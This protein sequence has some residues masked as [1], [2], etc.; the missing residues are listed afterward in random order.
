MPYGPFTHLP[1][2]AVARHNLLVVDGDER[3]L[4]VLE[5]SLR[6]AGYNVA[7][8]QEVERALE[9]IEASRPDLILA[10]TRLPDADGFEL[11]GRLRDNP[12]WAEIPFMFLSSDGS[13][14]SKIRGLELGV[15]D[16][17]T[18]PIYIR[19]VIARV[20][21]E[22]DRQRRAGLTGRSSDTKARFTGE[23]EEMGVVDL[24]QTIDIA[25]KSGV[26][27]LSSPA[28]ERGA[29]FFDA[30]SITNAEVG[31][32]GGERAVY[33]LLLWNEGSFDV[34]FRPVRTA[35]RTIDKST[36]ALLIEGMHLVDEWSRL[37]E[38]LPP[39][40]AVL[41]IDRQMLRE[42]LHATPDEHN[43]MIRLVDGV[44]TV[45]E[46]VRRDGCDDI[47][48]LRKLVNLYF[49]GVVR[50]AGEGTERTSFFD[51]TRLDEKSLVETG[52][53][54][55]VTNGGSLQPSPRVTEPPIHRKET[56]LAFS[57]PALEGTEYSIGW[58][59]KST[60][61][62]LAVTRPPPSNTLRNFAAALSQEPG[63]E[64]YDSMVDDLKSDPDVDDAIKAISS[65]PP[66]AAFVRTVP[67]IESIDADVARG[68][69]AMYTL[70][71]PA[72]MPGYTPASVPEASAEPTSEADDEPI[73]LPSRSAKPLI[74]SLIGVGV[75]LAAFIGLSVLEPPDRAAEAEVTTPAPAPPEGEAARAAQ[76][77]PSPLGEV[78][79]V[80]PEEPPPKAVDEEAYR[81]QLER[82]K[83][84]RGQKAEQAYRKAIAINDQG[85]EAK[86]R[87]AYL[88]LNRGRT[89]QA[90]ALAE[91]A[92]ELDPTSSFAWITLGAARQ[93]LRDRRGARDAYE[94]CVQHGKGEYVAECRALIR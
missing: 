86:A 74:W 66:P 26:L 79:A 35:G 85:S 67:P 19:E 55:S 38:Q 89:R 17:L 80:T 8:C 53:A 77:A 68:E 83:S 9:I 37:V 1:R 22:L 58:R 49:E 76:A 16:Y 54:P 51:E 18:K 46:I 82:A 36:Q 30:G 3:S 34:E 64:G 15:E 50:E 87:L 78:P 57:N 91:S 24:I 71:K 41:E 61:P 10:D 92:A 56:P 21:L 5:V 27:Y 47:E 40:H 11:V 13:I 88:L 73:E 20:G 62:P 43:S 42:R 72:P 33:R 29:I 81:A 63:R 4:R 2:L 60:P 45:G 94:N 84:L 25:K 23:L 90:L 44:H 31:D 93:L 28:E 65:N 7:S 39:L 52:E 48:A 12:E 59:S 75:V 70:P 6:K 32:L 14:E 69:E